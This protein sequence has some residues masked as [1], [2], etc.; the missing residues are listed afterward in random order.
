LEAP[1]AGPA[2][3]VHAGLKSTDSNRPRDLSRLGHALGEAGEAEDAASIATP[4]RAA[5]AIGTFQRKRGLE[6]DGWAKPGGETDR[7]LANIRRRRKRLAAQN[8]A[9]ESETIDDRLTVFLEQR[10]E[11]A[12][13]QADDL[14][15][16]LA[17]S[18]GRLFVQDHAG[19]LDPDAARPAVERA[20]AP[21]RAAR[22]PVQGL[23]QPKS[24][25]PPDDG[26]RPLPDEETLSE[27]AD[28]EPTSEEEPPEDETGCVAAEYIL[29]EERRLPVLQ[30]R[31]DLAQE[32]ID[33][34]L[35]QIEEAERDMAV[36]LGSA[37]KVGR[38]VRDCTRLRDVR[39]IAACVGVHVLSIPVAVTEAL[40][41][42]NAAREQLSGAE[43]VLA[44][45]IADHEALV[46]RIER[47]KKER[48]EC[49][50]RKGGATV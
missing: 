45:A 5:Q 7:T 40:S 10:A 44:D 43:E 18:V 37:G 14:A 12:Q 24:K 15:A 25:G 41:R 2:K 19:T 20:L 42:R 4:D 21:W 38:D 28:E 33:D 23:S 16:L 34:L 35:R 6:V 49:L 36:S 26:S 13:V 22:A 3:A 30:K 46:Q 17:T 8:R 11:E 9:P 31:I 29:N 32:R 47:L 39:L 1:T 50:R 48:A 27:G